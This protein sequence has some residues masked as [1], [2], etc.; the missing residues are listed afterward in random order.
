MQG[1][2]DEPLNENGIRQAEAARRSI[3]DMK[4]DAVY[5]SPLTRAVQTGEIIGGVGRNEIITDDRL[6]EVDFGKYEMKSYFRLGPA[7]TL[8]WIFPTVLRAPDTVEPLASMI[9]RSR[10]FLKE[11]EGKD[12]EN[13][14]IA[15]HGG[16]MRTLCGYLADSANGI[17][18]HPRPKN[19]EIRVYESSGGKH[20]LLKDIVQA[21]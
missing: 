11:L 21:R 13:V 3:G 1:R 15:C 8:Y 12:Y 6:I 17:L 14:L 20:R 2:T 10:S 5:T 7:M 19:C 9:K 4:F 16:I 18:W